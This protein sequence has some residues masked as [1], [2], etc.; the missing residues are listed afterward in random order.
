MLDSELGTGYNDDYLCSSDMKTKAAA[1]KLLARASNIGNFHVVQQ[2]KAETIKSLNSSCSVSDGS[3]CSERMGVN[4]R[5][6]GGAR[7]IDQLG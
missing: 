4:D 3:C 6:S 1:G 5:G 7:S 2:S